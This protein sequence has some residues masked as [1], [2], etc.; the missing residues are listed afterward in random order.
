[1]LKL[2][3]AIMMALL[4]TACGGGDDT[5]EEQALREM[6]RVCR[7]HTIEGLAR[8]E[9][10]GRRWKVWCVPNGGPYPNL[11]GMPPPPWHGPFTN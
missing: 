4:L 5:W 3:T 11:P 2:L 9:F 8:W 1:M 6:M 7:T 10:H